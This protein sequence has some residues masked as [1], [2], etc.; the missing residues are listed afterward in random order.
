MILL[1]TWGVQGSSFCESRRAVQFLICC[2]L[3]Q[4]GGDCFKETLF[5]P[6]LCGRPLKSL[7]SRFCCGTD[8][9]SSRV[10]L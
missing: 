3:I 4:K 10:L 5:Q 1:I 9:H 8:L 2:L 6:G 7:K